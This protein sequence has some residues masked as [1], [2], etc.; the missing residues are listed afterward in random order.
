MVVFTKYDVLVESLRPADDS[1][2]YGDIEEDIAK[3]EGGIEHDIGS[4]IGA[5]ESP[6]DPSVL[7][8]ADEELRKMVKH[9]ERTL[10][11]PWVAVSGQHVQ[12]LVPINKLNRSSRTQ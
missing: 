9:F 10:G 11:V 7:S 4:T 2:F 8:R 3:L 1:D 6:I 12:Y 5:N